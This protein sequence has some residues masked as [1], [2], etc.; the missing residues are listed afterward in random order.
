LSASSTDWAFRAVF[1]AE[2]DN[3]AQQ[4]G[5]QIDAVSPRCATSRQIRANLLASKGDKFYIR[6]PETNPY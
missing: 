4:Q 3:S 6:N 5:N 2:A 1:G